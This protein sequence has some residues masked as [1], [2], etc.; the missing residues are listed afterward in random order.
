MRSA[1]WTCD[2]QL[3][4]TTA[5]FP[6]KLSETFSGD[7]T[8]VLVNLTDILTHWLNNLINYVKMYCTAKIHILEWPLF[9]SPSN[10]NHNIYIFLDY[11]CVPKVFTSTAHTHMCM[12][13]I[14]PWAQAQG[15]LGGGGVCYVWG[16]AAPMQAS[17]I[18]LQEFQLA[19]YCCSPSS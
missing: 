14:L 1:T 11:M 12:L 9:T 7:L 16:K 17:L 10:T 3:V 8:S 15:A 2:G 19:G 6:H 13:L 5:E 18:D 4:C